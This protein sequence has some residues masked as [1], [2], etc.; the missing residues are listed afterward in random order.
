[1]GKPGPM[2]L[3]LRKTRA[4]ARIEGLRTDIWRNAA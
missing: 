3:I 4:Q 2:K 1:V